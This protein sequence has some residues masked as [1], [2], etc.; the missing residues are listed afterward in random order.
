MKTKHRNANRGGVRHKDVIASTLAA[1]LG[2]PAVPNDG[3]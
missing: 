2:G 3:G 1:Y